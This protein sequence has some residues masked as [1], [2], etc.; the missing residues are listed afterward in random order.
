[1]AHSENIV[2]GTLDAD[3]LLTRCCVLELPD[4]GDVQDDCTLHCSWVH[5][6]VQNQRVDAALRV[7]DDYA[8]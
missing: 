4:L 3:W 2:D 8:H 6:G 1:M 7:Q 5:L